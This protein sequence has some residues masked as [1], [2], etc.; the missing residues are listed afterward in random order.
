MIEAAVPVAAMS[1][2]AAIAL[3][4]AMVLATSEFALS[5]LTRAI[6]E[7][8]IQEEK[9]HAGA[10]MELV[11]QRRVVIFVLRGVR[12]FLQVVFAVSMATI[13]LHF[14]HYW[15]LGGLVAIVVVTIAQFLANSIIATRWA[16]RNPTGITLFFTPLMTRLVA[17][18]HF[19]SP[20]A[21][22]VKT[23]L[24]QS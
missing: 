6:V 10:L 5:K 1:I 20:A 15:W 24:P 11:D 22:K 7:D 2:L 13:A 21:Q 19:F 14:S 8:L 4:F 18:A 17:I 16:Q 9:K 23:Y 12:T 3:L